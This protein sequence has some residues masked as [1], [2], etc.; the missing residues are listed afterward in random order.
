M[1]TRVGAIV[2]PHFAHRPRTECDTRWAWHPESEEHLLGKTVIAQRVREEYADHEGM[3]VEYEVPIAEVWRIA[4]VMAIFPNGWRIAHECQLASITVEDLQERTEDYLHAG[5]DVCWWLGKSAAT[6]ANREWC[7]ESG[8][9]ST[10]V[11]FL[12][13]TSQHATPQV[14]QMMENEVMVVISFRGGRNVDPSA[15]PL[16]DFVRQ[17]DV[18]RAF[19][20]WPNLSYKDL[21][22]GLGVRQH[23][24]HFSAT[25]G[26]L[27]F[28]ALERI[29][30]GEQERWRVRDR[31]KLGYKGWSSSYRLLP[32][33]GVAAAQACARRLA[34]GELVDP[35]A[36]RQRSSAPAPAAEGAPKALR[37][38][39]ADQ[40][41]LIREECRKKNPDTARLLMACR[42]FLHGDDLVV[43]A[44]TNMTR[45]ML[46][47]SSH[48]AVIEW[49]VFEVCKAPRKVRIIG[50]QQLTE[51]LGG[52]R[53]CFQIG[54]RIAR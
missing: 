14:T 45:E 39:P 47:W 53:V 18:R 37:M 24:Q 22:R 50:A 5:V 42:V 35:A 21:L 48:R 41:E 33:A 49:A 9:S 46:R 30:T 36:I 29:G 19:E 6:G 2:R 28:E 38:F 34:R 3:R 4:D 10:R 12:S 32:P 16:P 17:R 43:C 15:Q 51:M 8:A 27:H 26:S 31:S 44:A 40:W 25:V 54:D 23:Q 20:I 1:V 7:I 13:C 11:L 52:A